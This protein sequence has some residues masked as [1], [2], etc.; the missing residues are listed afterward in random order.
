MD[1]ILVSTGWVKNIYQSV[2]E[3]LELPIRMTWWGYGRYAKIGDVIHIFKILISKL[4][5]H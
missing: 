2:V 5:Y 1:L 4:L 3:N